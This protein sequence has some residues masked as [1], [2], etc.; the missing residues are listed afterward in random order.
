[1]FDLN[2]GSC[3]LITNLSSNLLPVHLLTVDKGH[4]SAVINVDVVK[5]T[6]SA[7]SFQRNRMSSCAGKVLLRTGNILCWQ[8]S[9]LGSSA[10]I[11]Q[12]MENAENNEQW[13]CR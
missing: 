12:F 13:L 2:Q 8:E 11:I 4:L 7:L 3:C 10:N 1:M 9:T 6:Q 5:I